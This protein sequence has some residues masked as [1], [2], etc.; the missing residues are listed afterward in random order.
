VDPDASYG[1]GIAG[2]QTAQSSL[3]AA[4]YHVG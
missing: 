4:E 3:S 1:M 2:R